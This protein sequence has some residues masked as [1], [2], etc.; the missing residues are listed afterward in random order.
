MKELVKQDKKKEVERKML[1][2]ENKA[3]IKLKHYAG[4]LEQMQSLPLESKIIMTKQRIKQWYEA[5]NGEV[6][7]SF[8]GGKD[9]TVLK[10]IVDSMYSHVPSVFLNTGLEYPEIKNFVRDIKE[11][12]Y[13]CF[14]SDVEMIRPEMRFDEVIKNYGYPVISKTVA[15]TIR[16]AKP[17]T[18]RWK[19]LHGQLIDD[20]GRKSIYNC[21][22]WLFMLDAPFKVSEQCCDIM[23]K[24]PASRYE[25]ETKRKP[26]IGQMA[27]E[28][29]KRKSAWAKTGCNAFDKKTQQSNPLAF[30]TDQ[31]VLEY[32]L[33]YKVP[34]ASIYGQIVETGN[35]IERIDGQ[36]QKL[37]TTGCKRTGC[38]FCMF[39]IHLENHPN[40][41]ERMKVTHPKQYEYCM[42][43]I[44]EGGLGLDEILNYVQIKH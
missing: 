4:D 18:I 24:K 36:H 13:D 1:S 35:V 3:G 44:K 12:K 21:N 2:V 39:G 33:K 28:S 8:S 32:I 5:W 15:N 17:N 42:K 43:S 22:K 10:H 16:F 19:K 25:R 37:T 40:R 9:S 27:S 20:Q 29:Q 6:Y 7:V 34:Y 26:F 38:M 14:N 11:G 30:W 23:K 41:F 31:D